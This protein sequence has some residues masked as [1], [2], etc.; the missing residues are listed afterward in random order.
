MRATQYVCLFAT[1]ISIAMAQGNKGEEMERGAALIQQGYYAQAEN[2]FRTLLSDLK[3]KLGPTHEDTLGAQF[4]LGES[5]LLGGRPEQA[6][7]ILGPTVRDIEKQ[8]G[9]VHIRTLVAKTSFG[10]ALRESG[11][12]KEAERVLKDTC[13]RMEEIS[14]IKTD[15]SICLNE[16]ATAQG[17]Q[18]KF[19]QAIDNIQA[20]LALAEGDEA[21][22]VRL[23]VA[24]GQY[25]VTLGRAHDARRTLERAETL[26]DRYLPL[27]HPERATLY[28]GLGL[29]RFYEKNYA[30]AER[31][32]RESLRIA[33]KFLGP[34]HRETA[35]VMSYLAEAVRRQGRKTEAKELSVRSEETMKKSL[36]AVSVWALRGKE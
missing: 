22:Q 17:Y 15:R 8:K 5:I 7:D 2:L 33:E 4:Y 26:T 21:R 32:I 11:N 18:G 27:E 3:T 24:R 19:K 34:N 12:F 1:A 14:T 30:E 6:L 36:G 23:L 25:E 10:A 16:L 13:N 20:A 29:V 31:Y 9:P 28:S 35:V